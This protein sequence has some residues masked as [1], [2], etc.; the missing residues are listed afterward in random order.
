MPK[1][2]SLSDRAMRRADDRLPAQARHR[3]K[4]KAYIEQV[5]QCRGL[6]LRRLRV[7]GPA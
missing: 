6:F 3:A 2:P 5:R 7:M 1:V 4:R